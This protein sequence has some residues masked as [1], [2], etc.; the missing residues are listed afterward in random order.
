MDSSQ[1]DAPSP[2]PQNGQ[3][4]LKKVFCAYFIRFEKRNNF[5]EDF[6]SIRALFRRENSI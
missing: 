3:L 5:V 6:F 2:H 1:L 4:A